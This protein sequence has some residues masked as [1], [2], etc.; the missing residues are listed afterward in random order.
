MWSED[1]ERCDRYRNGDLCV[2]G[3]DLFVD[4]VCEYCPLDDS[5]PASQ[6]TNPSLPKGGVPSPRRR[7]ISTWADTTQR[8]QRASSGVSW[9]QREADELRESI[10]NPRRRGKALEEDR[11]RLADLERQIREAQG[12]GSRQSS[13]DPAPQRPPPKRRSSERSSRER[14]SASRR[15]SEGRDNQRAPAPAREPASRERL[16]RRVSAAEKVERQR[17]FRHRQP[18]D[19]DSDRRGRR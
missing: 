7:A 2:Q 19:G 17:E 13:Q 12:L 10:G 16:N 4:A 18:R 6:V 14:R 3:E 11:Q 8:D 15:P 1:F 9:L 5:Q